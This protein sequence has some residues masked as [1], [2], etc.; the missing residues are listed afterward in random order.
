V[1]ALSL[2]SFDSGAGGSV[3]QPYY[4]FARSGITLT[5]GGYTGSIPVVFSDDVLV[6]LHVG[7][8]FRYG[9][10]ATSLKEMTH[11]RR[12]RIPGMPP[13]RWLTSFRPALT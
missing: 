12:F 13:P 8:R 10:S 5:P 9:A 3:L 1:W 2:M 7:V 4:R 6:A 11:H